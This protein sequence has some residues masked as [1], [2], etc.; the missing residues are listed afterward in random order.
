MSG[1][2]ARRFV[3]LSVLALS[4]AMVIAQAVSSTSPAVA[5]PNC[6]SPSSSTPPSQREIAQYMRGVADEIFRGHV[7]SV[8]KLYPEAP[9][10]SDVYADG[11]RVTFDVD[12]VW[13]GDVTP[14]IVVVQEPRSTRL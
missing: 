10:E 3:S 4:A 14:T 12:T 11:V 9:P 8:D 7:T 5:L 6:I 13:K 1:C 2:T